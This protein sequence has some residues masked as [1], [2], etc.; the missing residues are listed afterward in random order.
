MRPLPFQKDP[1]SDKKGS[2]QKVFYAS[3]VNMHFLVKKPQYFYLKEYTYLVPAEKVGK[4]YPNVS[5]DP[6]H[7]SH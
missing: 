4:N 5:I 2:K 6:R 7:S 3:F 1:Q